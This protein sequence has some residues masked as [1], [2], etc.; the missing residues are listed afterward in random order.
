MESVAERRR[1]GES[2]LDK[3]FLYEILKNNLN[4]SILMVIEGLR[5]QEDA[6]RVD[7]RTVCKT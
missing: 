2:D 4:I 3:L 5:L 6:W 7:Y 1:R